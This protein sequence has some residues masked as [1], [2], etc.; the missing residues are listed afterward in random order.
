MSATVTYANGT[1]RQVKNLGWLLRHWKNVEQ[2]QV[3]APW[4]NAE[5]RLVVILGQSCAHMS[6]DTLFMSRAVLHNFLDRPVFRGVPVDWLGIT[7][8]VGDKVYKGLLVVDP[9]F[10]IEE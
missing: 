9:P 2:I 5:G 7:C 1:T 6:Y 8:K 3:S 4:T 10:V